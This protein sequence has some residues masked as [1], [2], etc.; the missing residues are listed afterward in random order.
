MDGLRASALG[1]YGNTWHATSALDA[2]AA[3]S[4]VVDWMWCESIELSGACRS[5]WGGGGDSLPRRLAAAG[6]AMTLVT[7][8]ASVANWGDAAGFAETWRV[9]NDAD[10]A[11]AE[12]AD[13]ATARLMAA[14]AERLAAWSSAPPGKARLAWIHA[15]G[16]H[17]PWDAPQELRAGLLEEDDPEPPTY[18]APPR[19]TTDDHDELLA[20]RAAYAA[21][22]IVLDECVGGLLA[23]LAESGVDDET[24]IVLAG[25]R[26]YALGEHGVVGG[27]G[28]GPYSELLHVPCLL[29]VPRTA[30]APPRFSGPATLIDVQATLAAWFGAPHSDPAS[31]LDLLSADAVSAARRQ[32]VTAAGGGERAIR[33]AAWMLR[34]SGPAIESAA[35][36]AGAR[37]ELY[38]K[39]DDR[40]EANEVANRCT[41]VAER[42]LAVLDLCADAN[43]AAPATPLDDDLIT[44]A[45]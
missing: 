39:P 21:Q 36:G 20:C 44:P 3:R 18:V 40:W 7:D 42:L 43:S 8:D 17:G 26:G 29:R 2:L 11:A 31:A 35:T 27:E 38:A 23:A 13:T 10:A 45:R 25:C 33:T 34:R 22:A 24:L 28:A 4:T 19:L 41:S 1:A 15:R 6:V 32:F 37:V 30:P 12:V 14:A 9:E 5:L 16:F